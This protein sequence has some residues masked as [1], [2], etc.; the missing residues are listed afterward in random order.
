[1]SLDAG[2]LP[3]YHQSYC[4]K[5]W[6]VDVPTSVDKTQNG[7]VCKFVETDPHLAVAKGLYDAELARYNLV[8]AS[9]AVPLGVLTLGG[10]ASVAIAGSLLDDWQGTP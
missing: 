3:M 1:M 5:R 2:S 7:T 9:S 8:Y 10:T 6:S 4:I